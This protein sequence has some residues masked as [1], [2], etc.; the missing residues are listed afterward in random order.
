MEKPV[1]LYVHVPF[2]AEKCDYCAFFS[3]EGA[4][5]EDVARYF[6]GMRKDIEKAAAVTGPLKTVFV[7]GGN[8]FSLSA[9]ALDELLAL[10]TSGCKILPECEFTIEG[11]PETVDADKIAALSRHRVTRVSLGVQS[12]RERQRAYIGRK[13]SLLGIEEKIK[14]VFKAGIRDVNLDLIYGIPGQTIEE[15]RKDLGSAVSL[16]ITHLS[17]YGLSVEPGS[18]LGARARPEEIDNG[19]AAEMWHLTGEFLSEEAGIKRYEISNYAKPGHECLHN[20]SFWRGMDY[21]GCGPAAV[22]SEG[23]ARRTNAADIR[24]W[25]EGAGWSVERVTAEERAREILMLDLRTVEGITFEEFKAVTGFDALRLAGE[26]LGRLE[27]AGLIKMNARA[28]FP[29]E[30]GMLFADS[31]AVELI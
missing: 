27:K 13:G 4:P 14:A 23:L 3:V 11:N 5:G 19:L 30:K 26:S 10:I 29:T 15:W 6:R 24:K 20:L 21:I 18:P 12:F 8:P 2:C 25:S 22:S 1:S 16:G 7:G 31:V 28:L 17:A 9:E